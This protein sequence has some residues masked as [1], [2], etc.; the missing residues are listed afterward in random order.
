MRIEGHGGLSLL[1]DLALVYLGL[2][3]GT[4]HHLD[5]SESREIAARLRRWQPDKDPALIDHVIRDVSLSYDET[6]DDDEVAAAVEALG[7]KLSEALRQ[8]ILEDL[9]GIARADGRVVQA[10]ED[11]IHR[12]ADAWHVRYEGDLEQPSA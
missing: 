7:S 11:F 1:Q 10:E 12:V 4:D 8:S 6:T 2:A 3:R 5:P 9:A